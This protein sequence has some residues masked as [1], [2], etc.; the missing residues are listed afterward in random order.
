M[1]VATLCAR[2][3]SGHALHPEA[4]VDGALR[5]CPWCATADLYVQKDF[6]QGLGLFIVIVG[7]V[8]STVFRQVSATEAN[9]DIE[10]EI[11]I[12]SGSIVPTAEIA[13]IV[14]DPKVRAFAVVNI[15]QLEHRVQASLGV[16]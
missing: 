9:P 12:T 15:E 11:D 6:P 3:R 16:A 14:A 10:G 5:A 2:C 4:L 13:S 8:I 1:S 7:F